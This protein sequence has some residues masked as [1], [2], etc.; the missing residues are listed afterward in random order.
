IVFN[1]VQAARVHIVMPKERLFREDK[2]EA[3]ASVL[4][5][6][7]GGQTLSKQKVAGIS[8]LVASSVEGLSPD[9]ITI[10]DYDG[11]LLSSGQKSD[12]VAG[13]SSSQL[14]VR[15]QVETY[16]ENKAQTM[17]NDVLGAG[18]SVI[19]VTADLDFQ[20]LERT[21]ETYDPNAPSIRSEERVKSSNTISDKAAEAEEST[22]DGSS[23][24][25]VTNYE[26]NKTVEHIIG[27]SGSISRLAVAVMVDGIYTPTEN[28]DGGTEMIYQPRS[29]EEL[30]RLAAIVRNAVGYDQ[31]RNDQ[32]EMVNIAFDRRDL[33]QDRDALDSVYQRDFYFQIG[34]KV[35]YVLM[36]ILALL[37]VRKKSRKLF[38]ALG[39]LMPPPAPVR[40]T[41]EATAIEDE[42]IEPI[43][44]QSRKPKL[45]DQMQETAREQPEELAKVIKT[46]MVE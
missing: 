36:I 14:D 3:S 29:Q 22:E 33:Q 30:D 9:N 35:G 41:V 12:A 17:L 13:L 34:Q 24:T 11:N 37:Y 45:V 6:L 40:A 32:I 18:T 28:A 44:A 21:S 1:E 20:Q 42:P 7:S 2:K 38:A 31:Q 8:H 10:V 43:V 4:L 16:L 25:V 15:K 5:K 19:R 46:M 39:K 26:L 23:E 27:S